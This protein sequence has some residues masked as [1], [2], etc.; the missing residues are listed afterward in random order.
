MGILRALLVIVFSLG[1]FA[2]CDTKKEAPH[3]MGGGYPSPQVEVVTIQ[4]HQVTLS[5]ELPG[6]TAA[7]RVAEIRPQVH[8]IITKRFFT[9]G[10]DVKA[11]EQLYQIDQAPYQAAY[12]SA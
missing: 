11:G 12:D 9:E 5:K 1:C 8:G 4:P 2:S 6:R 3:Q 7:Y 10:S